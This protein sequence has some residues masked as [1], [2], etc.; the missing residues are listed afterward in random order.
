[1]VKNYDKK[2]LLADSF[3][4]Q[5]FQLHLINNVLISKIIRANLLADTRDLKSLGF[6]AVPVRFRP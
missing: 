5:I 6:T 1:M 4:P 3:Q 2:S